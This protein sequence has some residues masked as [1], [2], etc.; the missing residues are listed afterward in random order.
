MKKNLFIKK[1]FAGRSASYKRILRARRRK[2]RGYYNVHCYACRKLVRENISK[3]YDINFNETTIFD[4]PLFTFCYCICNK[5]LPKMNKKMEE[6]KKMPLIKIPLLIND[7]ND[8]IAN[9]AI[10]R[11]KGV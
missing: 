5:C 6:I 4:I 8:I 3:H 9:A 11:L 2:L 10:K 7:P 1:P